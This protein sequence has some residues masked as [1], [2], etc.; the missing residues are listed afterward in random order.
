MTDTTAGAGFEYG[1]EFYRWHVSDLGK[2][3]MLIDRF[4]GG[5]P[6]PEFFELVDD[7]E[8]RIR[9]PIL[10]TLIATSIRHAHPDRSVERITR[11]VMGLNLSDVEF[12]GADSDD[13]EAADSPPG[14]GP[15]AGTLTVVPSKSPVTGSSP[16]STP[17]ETSTS[18]T[19]SAAQP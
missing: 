11:T 5:M 8:E 16:S 6:I 14:G 9:G 1:G 19:S 15:P 2:D 12:V 4:T 3:L 7:D 13:E 10:L 18:P 17:P